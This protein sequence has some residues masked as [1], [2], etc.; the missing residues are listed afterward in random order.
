VI[1]LAHN[2]DLRVIAEGVEDQPTVELLQSLGCDY[3]Q[4]FH[5]GR[6]M[7]PAAALEQLIS[8]GASRALPA[9][10]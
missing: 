7:P 5:L 2:L 1:E 10:E 8:L 4:G 3:A 6:P 9:A